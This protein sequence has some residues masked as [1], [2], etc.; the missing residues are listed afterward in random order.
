[1]DGVQQTPIEVTLPGTRLSYPLRRL[2]VG[3]YRQ[4]FS[5]S[6]DW[7]IYTLTGR[8]GEIAICNEL[9]SDAMMIR[10]TS[11][12]LPKGAIL[13]APGILNY[14]PCDEVPDGQTGIQEIY[15]YPSGDVNTLW[16]T[17]SLATYWESVLNDDT[18]RIQ[19]GETDSDEEQRLSFS[20]AGFIKPAGTEIIAIAVNMKSAAPSAQDPFT[21]SI[22]KGATWYWMPYQ[23]T[24]FGTGEETSR[25]EVMFTRSMGWGDW[26]QSELD[27]LQVGFLSGDMTG[28][29]NKITI[30]YLYVTAYCGQWTDQFRDYVGGNHLINRNALGRAERVL[31]YL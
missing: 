16:S 31:S 10:Y 2:V 26:T 30:N 28:K 19:A 18:N 3:G 13:F 24:Q 23:T 11:T 6:Q 9:H 27:G 14:W 17:K 20:G 22:K 21:V 4:N 1:M 29:D 8:I 7:F 12:F 25:K 15:S 5:S